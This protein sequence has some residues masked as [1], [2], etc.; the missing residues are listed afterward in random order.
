MFNANANGGPLPAFR[1]YSAIY[2]QCFALVSAV[3]RLT[4]SQ[5]LFPL[6][7][8]IDRTGDEEKHSWFNSLPRLLVQGC[9]CCVRWG[10]LRQ[11]FFTWSVA[12]TSQ[13]PLSLLFSGTF[14]YSFS[15]AR[16]DINIWS[17]TGTTGQITFQ[18]IFFIL[19]QHLP[20]LSRTTIGDLASTIEQ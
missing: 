2:Q 5:V 8:P 14:I 4:F 19:V 20:A 13:N 9:V 11:N 15:C 17:V 18:H 16:S 3:Y 1:K 12:T 10:W 7:V 6:K